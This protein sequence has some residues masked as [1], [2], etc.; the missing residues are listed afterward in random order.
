MN[1]DQPYPEK[2]PV[3]EP[4]TQSEDSIPDNIYYLNTCFQDQI[5]LPTDISQKMNIFNFDETLIA[6][7][8]DRVV[9][10]YQGLFWEHSK[11]DICFRNLKKAQWSIDGLETWKAK[12]VNVFRLIKPDK[13][14]KPR[15]HRFAVNPPPDFKGSCNPLKVGKWYTHVYQTKVQVNGEMKTLYSRRM[16]WELKRLCGNDYRPRK[17]DLEDAKVQQTQASID[18]KQVTNSYQQPQH[19]Q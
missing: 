19:F 5:G 13:R 9:T 3:N 8:F 2:I 11:D 1:I 14:A 18:Y 15:A 16:A 17:Y 7:G 4:A 12:G 10:T 6:K